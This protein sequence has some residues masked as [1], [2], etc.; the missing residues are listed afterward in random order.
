MQI[1]HFD[2]FAEIAQRSGSL[3]AQPE[4]GISEKN[5]ALHSKVRSEVRQ[6]Q[7]A[8]DKATSNLLTYLTCFLV[9]AHVRA[10]V[11]ARAHARTHTHTQDNR[12]GQVRR[13][14]KVSKFKAL[15]C[16]TYNPT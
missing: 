14:G 9:C 8:P 11:G 13:L 3:M 15:Q 1:C 4:K 7:A 16:L 6:C 2:F 10:Y 12:V 5:S